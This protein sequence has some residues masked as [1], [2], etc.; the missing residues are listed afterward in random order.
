VLLLA[1]SGYAPLAPPA[2]LENLNPQ[3]AV[4][5]VAPADR[6]GL[7]DPETLEALK[8]YPTLR[9]DENGWIEVVTDGGKMW[10]ASERQQ[11]ES[12]HDS[13]GCAAGRDRL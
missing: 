3:L 11:P 6:D 7:P 4:I 5:S 9:T 13:R 10:V 1:Q 2:L 8:D 12:T